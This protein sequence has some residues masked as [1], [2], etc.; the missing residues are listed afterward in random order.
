MELQQS[1]APS[2]RPIKLGG[3]N[4]KEII[5]Y[6]QFHLQNI[7]KKEKQNSQMMYQKIKYLNQILPL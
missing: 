3:K 6:R 1:S 2:R 5:D 4:I 7:L